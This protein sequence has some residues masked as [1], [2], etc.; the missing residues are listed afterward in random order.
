MSAK[1]ATEL[2]GSQK[3]AAVL[4]QLGRDLAARVLRCMTDTEAVSLTL[5]IANLPNLDKEFIAELMGEFVDSVVAVKTVGQGGVEAAREILGERLSPKEAN[6][7]LEQFAGTAGGNPLGFLAHVEAYQA[8]S[9]LQDEH[10]QTVAVILSYLPSESAAAIVAAMPEE[11]RASIA[12]RVAMLERV[13]PAVLESTAAVLQRK[14][15]GI[16]K[17]GPTSARSG[18]QSLVEILNNID[19]G[20]EKRILSD[21]D[22]IDPELADRVRS[23][24]F[25]FEDV[26]ALDDRTLQR[27]LRQIVP[28]DLA[29]ALKGVDNDMRDIVLRNL[30]ERAALDLVDEIDTLG[31]VR[32]ST[33]EAA[34]AAVVRVVRELEAAGEITLARST[35]EMVD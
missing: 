26:M 33:V 35:E 32:V 1:V 10:P 8:A 5:E 14:L 30:S 31:P 21:L 23:Q 18:L 22:V 16:A 13:D 20:A 34:Q 15:A 17:S 25:V 24:M 4:V 3:A 12:R 27:I 11:M 9:F 6:E 7:I 28:K 19:Q 29:V 2:T